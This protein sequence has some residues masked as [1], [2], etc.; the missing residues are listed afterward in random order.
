MSWTTEISS[1]K[2][3]LWDHGQHHTRWTVLEPWL[4]CSQQCA[5]RERRCMKRGGAL[6]QLSRHSGRPKPFGPLS[7]EALRERIVRWTS[8]R[9][10]FGICRCS[11]QNRN[12]CG[13]NIKFKQNVRMTRMLYAVGHCNALLPT[14]RFVLVGLGV[15]VGDTACS[16]ESGLLEQCM[17]PRAD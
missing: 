6:R 11:S 12:F 2:P 9:A 16:R 7:R 8:W 15:C 13:S 10:T 14:R 5:D 4:H 17:L 3:V 1:R